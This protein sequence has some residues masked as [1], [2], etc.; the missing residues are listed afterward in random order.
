M[1][2]RWR[3]V[4]LVALAAIAVACAGCGSGGESPAE[5][6]EA[7][8]PAA[9]QAAS[10]TGP[11]GGD[12]ESRP[13]LLLGRSVMGG[14]FTH[15]GRDG[16]PESMPVVRDGYALTYGEVSGPPDIASSAVQH[17]EQAPEG[18]IVV[19]KFCFV[20]FL[21][22]DDADTRLAQQKGWV[23][24]VAAKAR[25]RGQHLIVGNAL[26]QVASA[27]TPQLVAEHRAFNA[28]LEGF[29][30]DSG[31]AV[32]VLD[33]HGTLAG[34]DG[35]LEAGYAASPDDSHLND[36]GYAELDRVLFGLLGEVAD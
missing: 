2:I 15:W 5:P 8:Q 21:G 33:L 22:D 11:E 3:L 19:F 4:V 14:W 24:T 16:S 17:M 26:P 34:S 35:A 7:R 9:E 31:G 32:S 28:W 12:S 10:A 1:V 25:E 13:V 23:E 18:G 30:A 6:S 29:A 20:D 36:R 27:T